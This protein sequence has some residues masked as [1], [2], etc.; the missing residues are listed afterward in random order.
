MALLTCSSLDK[1]IDFSGNPRLKTL[2]A[3]PKPYMNVNRKG[4]ASGKSVLVFSYPVIATSGEV[5]GFLSL[6]VP[7]RAMEPS[8]AAGECR[9]GDA[10]CPGDL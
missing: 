2:L 7:H 5:M 8:A 1:P 3:D 6:S 10:Q 9:R 4:P